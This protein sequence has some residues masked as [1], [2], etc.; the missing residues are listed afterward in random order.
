M[1]AQEE[2][3]EKSPIDRD[4]LSS[5]FFLPPS[6]SLL[7]SFL[8][9]VCPH[10]PNKVTPTVEYCKQ[11][12]LDLDQTT[13]KVGEPSVE[14]QWQRV[15]KKANNDCSECYRYRRVKRVK[16]L[17]GLKGSVVVNTFL[18]GTQ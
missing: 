15:S 6:S 18:D 1:R 17:V 3:S 10:L 4:S 12:V 16:S 8:V 9:L 11:M 7:T 2:E 14:C 5:L 13:N